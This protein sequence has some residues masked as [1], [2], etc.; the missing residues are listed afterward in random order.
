MASIYKRGRYWWISYRD[1]SGR[2]ILESTKLSDREAAKR[3]ERHYTALEKTICL[4]GTPLQGDISISDFFLEFRKHREL[5]VS[6][7]TVTRDRQALA[8]L[9]DVIGDKLMSR[10]NAVDIE[11]WFSEILKNHAPAGAN[12]LL[13]HVKIFF[14]TAARMNYL[15]ESPAADVKSVRVNI[16]APRILSQEE[17][18]RLLEVSPEHWVKL[19]RAALYTG[20]RSG[21][22]CRLH[23]SDFN[24]DI[25]GVTFQSEPESP[26]KSKKYRIV[27]IPDHSVDFFRELIREAGGGIM[28]RNESGKEWKVQWITHGFAA[29][30]KRAGVACTFHDL[31]RTYGGWLVMAGADL[32][33]V[34]QNLGHADIQTTIRNYAGILDKHKVEQVNKMPV[35]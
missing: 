9:I 11:R 29:W 22:L 30:T 4:R 6:P 10:I 26:T 16:Q 34:Q 5:R 1:D 31:R 25:P 24:P 35:V 21:E 18:G 20:G 27:P 7:A 15:S 23:C 12:C 32:V 3:L 13:R 14:N 19:I 33:T 17:V 8:S 28:L 2:R